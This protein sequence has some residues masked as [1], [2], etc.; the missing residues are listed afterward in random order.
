MTDALKCANVRIEEEAKNSGSW[1]GMTSLYEFRILIKRIADIK[2]AKCSITM[3]AFLTNVSF[4]VFKRLSGNSCQF[5]NF[6]GKVGNFWFAI[7]SWLWAFEK[8][9]TLLPKK[10]ISV[11][12]KVP[13]HL[14]SDCTKW[15]KQTNLGENT[16][17]EIAFEFKIASKFIRMQW[18]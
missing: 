16:I 2:E 9:Y 1:P 18:L 14:Y 17:S 5:H 8:T 12:E 11:L 13:T 4:V 6:T 3:N 15:T 10:K 7:I